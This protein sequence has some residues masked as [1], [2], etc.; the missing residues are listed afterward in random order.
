MPF[1]P[2]AG[3]R[4]SDLP[5]HLGLKTVRDPY[6]SEELVAIP[7]LRPDWAVIHVPESDARGNARIY[8]SP[9][10]DRLAARAARRV[11]VTAEQ[12]VPTEVLAEQPELT[13]IPELFVEAVVHA[14]RGAWPGS[15]HPDYEVDYQ[16]VERYLALARE[17]AGLRAHLDEARH[18]CPA[19]RPASPAPVRPA[20][21]VAGAAA[22][23]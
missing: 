9:F 18:V 3:F 15:C 6:G 1:L 12:I 14:P 2:I 13:A 8:G 11:I 10:W 19:D 7:R 21:S 4:G 5:A 23:A 17:P 16:A 20:D 22:P